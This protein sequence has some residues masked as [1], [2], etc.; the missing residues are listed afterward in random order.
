[1][2]ASALAH[3]GADAVLTLQAI[4]SRLEAFHA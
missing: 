1:M 3:A 4:C 2:P